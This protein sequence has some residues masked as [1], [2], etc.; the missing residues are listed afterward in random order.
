VGEDNVRY[1][2][3]TPEGLLKLSIRDE[4][5]RTTGTLTWRRIED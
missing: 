1:Y 5:G 2:E 3:F 4:N